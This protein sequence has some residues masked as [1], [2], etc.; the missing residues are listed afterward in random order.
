MQNF[1]ASL[2][3][4]E[5]LVTRSTH[6]Q[7]PKFAAN[8]WNTLAISTEFPAFVSF[9][10]YGK[11]SHKNWALTNWKSYSNRETN[12]HLFHEFKHLFW[13]QAGHGF[14]DSLGSFMWCN[15]VSK[16]R[17]QIKITTIWIKSWEFILILVRLPTI[18]LN[19][20]KLTLHQGIFDQVPC[21]SSVSLNPSLDTLGV[22]GLF[23]KLRHASGTLSHLIFDL[24]FVPQN[25]SLFSKLKA[26]SN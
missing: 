22:T 14:R 11:Q 8:P 21:F 3:S 5:C 7:K 19:Y 23:L 24:V 2:V 10:A 18:V 1:C 15:G 9:C 16:R 17:L 26:L 13:R 4:V 20:F 25:S 12:L 6:A